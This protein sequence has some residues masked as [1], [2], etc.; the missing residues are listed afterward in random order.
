MSSVPTYLHS[1]FFF[2]DTATTEIYT[3]SL[4]DALPICRARAAAAAAPAPPD[5]ARRNRDYAADSSRSTVLLHPPRRARELLVSS[6]RSRPRRDLQRK[7]LRD[8]STTRAPP[9]PPSLRVTR[10]R[11]PSRG[12]PRRAAAGAARPPPPR[13]R[14]CRRR[15]SRRRRARTP[16]AAPRRARRS[17][18]SRR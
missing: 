16:A 3:L 7:F 8:R 18:E 10:R 4:H 2:N 12:L 15:E 14:R 5:G 1:F 9:D 6:W 11:A 13:R 17:R